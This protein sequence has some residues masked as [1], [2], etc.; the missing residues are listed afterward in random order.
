MAETDIPSADSLP[1]LPPETVLLREGRVAFRPT[2]R[3]LEKAPL[4]LRNAA[5]LLLAG[6]LLPWYGHGG[7]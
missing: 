1:D 6:S 4:L 7:T 2:E 3:Q 5:W